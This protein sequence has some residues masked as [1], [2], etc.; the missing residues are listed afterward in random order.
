M[1][2]SGDVD[3]GA[4]RARLAAW[5][6]A[7]RRP[8]PWRV[9]RSLYR[10]VVAELMCQQT[11]IATVLPYYA[12]WLQRL[13]DF[14]ALAAADPE[15]V[16]K[17]WEGLGYYRR[18]RQLQALA[19]VLAERPEP[20]RTAAAWG[21]LPGI[22][23]Y[24]AA[25]IASIEFGEPVAAVDGN[26]I[27]VLARL[28]ADGTLLR[29]A[30]AARRRFAGLAQAL[31]DPAD[32]GGHNEALMEL[33]ATV[34]RKRQPLCAACP[35]CNFCAAAR[36]GNPEA[37]PRLQRRASES[38]LC[39]RLWVQRGGRLLLHRAAGD[40]RR[41]ADLWELPRLDAGAPV[42][43][44]RLLAERTRA[45]GNQ[46]IRERLHAAT[47][48]A[49]LCRWVDG[50]ADWRWMDGRARAAAAISGPHRRWI[51]EMGGRL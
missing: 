18:A 19:R 32:P 16:L 4:L 39:D 48:G 40:A 10:T 41:L 5:Y 1:P 31:L 17:L 37:Y 12:R 25:A 3:A 43:P 11:Q 36:A 24:T 7:N 42:A 30:A 49:E 27:R 20:P 13:P 34:C 50:R 14:A 45:I 29:G 33:G 46:R 26:V 2:E 28:R 23:P 8:L 51:E 15:Q 6:R 35:L 9:E 47:A 38:V 44:V 22:G 21:A